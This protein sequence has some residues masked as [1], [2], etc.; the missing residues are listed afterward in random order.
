M[1]GCSIEGAPDA[2]SWPLHPVHIY[3]QPG[4]VSR[5]T[6]LIREVEDDSAD[7]DSEIHILDVRFSAEDRAL[8]GMRMRRR[9][10]SH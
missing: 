2:Y 5:R 7:T 6:G 9:Y 3:G 8:D 4:D 10:A 1:R